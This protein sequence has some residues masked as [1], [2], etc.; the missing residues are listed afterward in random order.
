MFLKLVTTPTHINI[1]RYRQGFA[2]NH[3]A[4]P[5]DCALTKTENIDSVN[6]FNI[7]NV[8]CLSFIEVENTGIFC[9]PLFFSILASLFIFNTVL[10]VIRYNI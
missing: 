3:H 10:R 9:L 1:F 4:G 5:A 2:G 6:V 8:L 7:S